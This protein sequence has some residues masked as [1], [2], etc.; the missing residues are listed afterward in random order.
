[1]AVEVVFFDVGGV[2]LDMTGEERRSLWPP[3][4]GMTDD[5]FAQ[6][7]WDAIGLRDQRHMDE[8]TERLV[9]NLGVAESDVPQLLQD[10]SAHWRR[11]E[12]LVEF[13]SGLR[14]THRLAIIGNIPS[15]GR[16]AF[17]TVLHLDEI[18]EAMFLSG[19]LGVEKPDR[20]IY[21]IACT[22]MNVRPEASVFV[23]DREENVEAAKAL[24]IAAHRHVDDDDTIR[25]LLAQLEDPAQPWKITR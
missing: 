10:F 16:F 15:S 6:N 2:L 11:N 25:W 12:R 17:E 19:E 21:E 4:L 20:A 24:G 7:V 23:D 8:I 3:R 18:F 22:A 13:L 9:R 5:A 14:A 1:M